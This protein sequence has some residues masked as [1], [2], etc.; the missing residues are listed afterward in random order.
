MLAVDTNVLARL[1]LADEPGQTERAA[2]AL[3]GRRWLI[4]LTVL[5]ETEWVLR[6][7]GGLPRSN[8][9]RSLRAVVGLQGAVV[10]RAEL[11]ESALTDFEAGVDFADALHLRGAAGCEAFL[12]FDRRLL[13]A[14]VD[15][16]TVPVREP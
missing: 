6:S 2:A 11:V 15:L 4:T 3:R 5:L 9:L 1:L 16:D 13:R 8:V 12:T 7:A 14:A 10:E